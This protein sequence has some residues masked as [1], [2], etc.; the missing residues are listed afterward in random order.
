MVGCHDGA[1]LVHVQRVGGGGRGSGEAAVG[2][3]ARLEELAG[4]V[5]GDARRRRGRD[6][7]RCVHCWVDMVERVAWRSP[8]P[9]RRP[10][11]CDRRELVHE[12][13]VGACCGW[14]WSGRSRCCSGGRRPRGPGR[15]RCVLVV[16]RRSPAPARRRGSSPSGTSAGDASAPG[17]ARLAVAGLN[18]VT[19]VMPSP[20]LVEV[21]PIDEDPPVGEH[22]LSGAEEVGCGVRHLGGRTGRR[23]EH[24]LLAAGG[25]VALEGQDLARIA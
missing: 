16:A 2:R 7:R 19:L 5:V 20:P 3:G 23:V 4:G 21:P 25:E 18:A 10:A 13:V 15:C 8:A 24:V 17:S 6:C 11:G 1:R 9:R 22:R 14:Q 12:R